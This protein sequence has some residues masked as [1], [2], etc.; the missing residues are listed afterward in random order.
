M[1]RMIFNSDDSKIKL[2]LDGFHQQ[3]WVLRSANSRW[4]YHIGSIFHR[5]DS[6]DVN[7]NYYILPVCM[8]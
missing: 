3:Y 7:L 2:S 4:I 1:E 5:V 6:E 8:I